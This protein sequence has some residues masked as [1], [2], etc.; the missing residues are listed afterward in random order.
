MLSNTLKYIYNHPLNANGKVTSLIR[1][2]KWQL[3]CR[4][5]KFP[6]VYGFTENSKLIMWKGLTG[7]TGNLYCGLMEYH[8]MGF[9]LHF[10]REEDLFIDIGA[11]VGAY[12]VLASGE[13][14]SRTIAVEPLPDTYAN[15]NENVSINQ[16]WDRVETLNIGLGSAKSTLKFTKSLDTVNH[17]AVEGEKD[18]LEVDV[19][20]LDNVLGTKSPALIK[21]DVEGFETEVLNGAS[22]TLKN[23]ELKAIIIELNGSGDRYGY[24]ESAIHQILVDHGFNPYHYEPSTKTLTKLPLF[25]DNNTIYIRDIDYVSNRV[26]HARKI[27]IGSVNQYI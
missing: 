27:K 19:D 11:N 16:M 6:I 9:L 24:D 18:V 3:N 15:L 21:I 4:L 7:A 25:G 22:N 26:Q 23:K 12:T 13:I 10:L 2:V 5:N 8:D 20:T 17:V 1:F 14:K